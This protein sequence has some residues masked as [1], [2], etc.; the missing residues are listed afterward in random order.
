MTYACQCISSLTLAGRGG[1]SQVPPLPP[2]TVASR[3]IKLGERLRYEQT[4]AEG[5]NDFAGE[6]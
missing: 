1:G 2:S 4:A 3:V 6:K 5:V